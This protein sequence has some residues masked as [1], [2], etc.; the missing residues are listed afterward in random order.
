MKYNT[1]RTGY[2]IKINSNYIYIYKQSQSF[3]TNSFFIC[4]KW[5]LFVRSSS[6][7]LKSDQR[8]SGF[9]CTFVQSFSRDTVINKQTET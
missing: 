1:F 5:D 2:I 3:Y 7:C 4:F 8:I 6:T 9:E